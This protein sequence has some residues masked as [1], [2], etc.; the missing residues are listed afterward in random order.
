[1]SSLPALEPRRGP[2]DGV[3]NVV[4]FNW[5]L[6]VVGLSSI[7]VGIVLMLLHFLPRWATAGVL[8][9]TLIAS[10]LLLA[11]LVVSHWVYDRSPIYQFDWARRTARQPT[12]VLVNL[13]S[14]LDESSEHL[15]R[16][17]AGT[18]MKIFDF[19][20]PATMT[21]PSIA[22]ARRFQAGQASQWLK[23]S[24][25]PAR[26]TALPLGDEEVDSAFLI[27]AA[28]EIREPAERQQLFD[29]LFR[30]LKP[31]GR[32]I[33]LEHLRDAANFLVFGPQ[34]VHFHSR[35]TWLNHARQAGFVV[36]EEFSITPFVRCFIFEKPGNS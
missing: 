9:G 11:S 15:R 25:Q 21:E 8:L 2:F 36:A 17:F 13:H 31:G 1:M 14:G 29:G 5:P 16:I 30:S 19:Y 34:F 24:T 33:L 3:V 12:H 23:D 35:T 10:Y 4:R 20:D 22:R 32:L 28:H 18:Q 7:G 6:Y 26:A 27:F